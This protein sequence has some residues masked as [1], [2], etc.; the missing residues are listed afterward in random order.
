MADFSKHKFGTRAIHA[1]AD[2]D[3]QDHGGQAHLA[4]NLRHTQVAGKDSGVRCY[5]K[6]H[7]TNYDQL[8]E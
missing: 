3:P 6:C 4:D 7:K 2:P 1:G 8:H 5:L